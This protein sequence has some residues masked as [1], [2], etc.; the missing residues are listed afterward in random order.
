[1]TLSLQLE[2]PPRRGIQAYE[3][4]SN[5]VHNDMLQYVTTQVSTFFHPCRSTL[6]E[7][8]K[9]CHTIGFVEFYSRLCS[10][11]ENKFVISAI[12]YDNSHL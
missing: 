3:I 10:H 11:L 1:M 5:Y 8:I 12:S 4:A 2:F 7:F 6:F 9:K